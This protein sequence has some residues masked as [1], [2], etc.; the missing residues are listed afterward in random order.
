MRS[1]DLAKLVAAMN[2]SEIPEEHLTRL[3]TAVNRIFRKDLDGVLEVSCVGGMAVLSATASAAEQGGN[4]LI[5][6]GAGNESSRLFLGCSG[7]EA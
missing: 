6:N 5:A 4:N 7:D 3:V 2:V 1:I